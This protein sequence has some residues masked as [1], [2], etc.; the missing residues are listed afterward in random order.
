MMVLNGSV[1]GSVCHVHILH[2]SAAFS[3]SS[4]I[5]TL[6]YSLGVAA[7]DNVTC[8]YNG[9]LANAE[10]NAISGCAAVPLETN[11][12]PGD[13]SFCSH[14]SESCLNAELM[15]PSVEGAGVAEPLSRITI[16]SLADLGYIVDYSTADSFGRANLVPGCACTTSRSLAGEVVHGESHQIIGLGSPGTKRRGLISSDG[17]KFAV[18]YGQALLA[19]E[20][21]EAVNFEPI[22]N[23]GVEYVG[24]KAVSVLIMDRDAIFSVVVTPKI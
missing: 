10:Y 24:D 9:T 7:R 3:L 2:A 20:A 22:D 8:T 14:W 5:G 17:Y 13:G 23:S 19:E 15:T 18:E 21:A 1:V 4:G 11:G 16:A 6:W 12:Q